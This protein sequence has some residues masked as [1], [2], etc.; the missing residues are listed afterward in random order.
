MHDEVSSAATSQLFTASPTAYLLLDER[1][2]IVAANDA[3]LART[4]RER[5]EL[6]GL[7]VFEAFPDNPATPET[8]ETRGADSLRASFESVLSTGEPHLLPGR[9]YDIRERADGAGFVRKTWS[10]RNSALT[11]DGSRVVGLL[12]HVEDLTDLGAPPETE[13][14]EPELPEPEADAVAELTRLA[15]DYRAQLHR[16][17]ARHLRIVEAF[18]GVAGAHGSDSRSDAQRRRRR[19]WQQVIGRLEE[20]GAYDW[21]TA[22]TGLAATIGAVRGAA[23]FVFD[24]GG[25]ARLAAASDPWAA[26][27]GD[28]EEVAG[29]G[30]ASDAHRTMLPVLV[31]D[32]RSDGRW[33]VFAALALPCGVRSAFCLPVCLAGSRLGA[34]CFFGAT[35]ATWTP[36]VLRDAALLA[37][38]AMPALLADAARIDEAELAGVDLGGFDEVAVAAGMLAAQ[39]GIPVPEASARLRAHVF[40]SGRPLRE[41][42]RDIVEGRLQLW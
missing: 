26:Q 5:A 36:A 33:P 29:E 6:V 14:P 40:A 18:A 42:A 8:P 9:R 4:G 23:V 17:S 21:L 27:S 7:D 28:L 24:G 19:L 20:H 13:L 1:L 16:M 32:L 37:D 2:R 22:V 38:L 41:S 30:P 12:S 25:L 35:G 3:F 10:V 11:D 34:M 39:L 31:E 15:A